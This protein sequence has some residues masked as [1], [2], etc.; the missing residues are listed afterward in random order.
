[1]T[2]RTFTTVEEMFEAM[3]KDEVQANDHTTVE[4]ALIEPGTFFVRHYAPDLDIYGV[5]LTDEEAMGRGSED[6][7]EEEV[8]ERESER[9][10]LESARR[11]GYMFTR[12]YSTMCPDGE[13]GDTHVSTMESITREAFEAARA[14]GWR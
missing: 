3:A 1:M 7:D 4:Q 11:R 14:R 9:Q 2:I 8:A 6:L 5:C 12:C 13:L 10:G